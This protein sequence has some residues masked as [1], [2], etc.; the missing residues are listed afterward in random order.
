MNAADK[1]EN[2]SADATTSTARRPFVVYWAAPLFSLSERRLNRTLSE[3]VQ[4]K[5]PEAEILLPQDFKFEGRYNASRT[6]GCIFRECLR[7]MDRSD[8]L[9]ACLDGCDS[10]SGTAF[11][12]GYA[13]A[14]KLPIVGV[15]T[16]FRR[17]QERGLNL[18][19]ARACTVLVNRPAFDENIEGLADDV[20][21]ALKKVAAGPR[22][23]DEVAPPKEKQP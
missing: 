23:G 13:Y 6:F 20:A 10:D 3:A 15:R 4:R 17:N 9:A 16:D 2:N 22:K 5:L 1:N 7:G 18:M 8:V 11:E 19:T 12:L 14:K 21:R